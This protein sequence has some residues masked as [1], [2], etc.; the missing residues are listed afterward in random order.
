MQ[1]ILVNL[2]EVVCRPFSEMRGKR[3]VEEKGLFR[4]YSSQCLH[5]KNQSPGFIYKFYSLINWIYV[6]KQYYEVSYF[7]VAFG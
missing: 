4:V 6:M 3:P 2:G 5:R 1:E 7:Q